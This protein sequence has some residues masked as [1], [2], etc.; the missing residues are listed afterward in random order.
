MDI[1]LQGR[2][3]ALRRVALPD[4]VDEAVKL[5]HAVGVDQEER[6]HGALPRPPEGSGPALQKNLQ[7]P[8]H[9]EPQARPVQGRIR[10]LTPPFCRACLSP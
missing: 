7:R 2:A 6:E 4:S 9:F 3:R 1:G 5:D 10:H 8:E